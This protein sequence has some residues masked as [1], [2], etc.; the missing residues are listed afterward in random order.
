MRQDIK[1]YVFYEIY[2]NSF[3]DNNNDGYGDLKGIISKLDYVK[4][5]GVDGIWLNP[6]YDSA[7]NDG[8][9]DVKDYFHTSPRFGTDEDFKE[10]ID[11][12]HKRNIKL[13]IDLVP[14]H[15]SEHNP[16]FLKSAEPTRNEFSDRYIWTSDPWDTP[17][18]YRLMTGR[19]DR[20]GSYLVNYFATQPALNYGFANITHPSWQMHYNDER[21]IKTRDFMVSVMEHYLALGVDGFRVDM[22][23]SLVKNDDSKDATV[24][25]WQYMFSKVKAKYPNSIF[26]SEWW[27]PYQAL[28]AGFDCDFVLDRSNAFYNDLVRKEVS[29]CGAQKSFLKIDSDLNIFDNLRVIE[30]VIN[31][32]KD[33]GYLSFF[34]CNHDISR[35][36]FKLDEKELRMF[37]TIIFTLPGV[38]FLYYGDEIMMKY[39]HDIPSKECGFQRTG[40]RTPMSWVDGYNQG[41]SSAKTEDLFLP[42]DET[43]S[44]ERC[45]ANKD[46][47]Y[48]HVKNLIK[49]RHEDESLQ[50]NEFKAIYGDS[51]VLMYERND[52]VVIINPSNVTKKFD[53]NG[54]IVFV[55]GNAYFKDN[56]L[57]VDSQTSVVIKR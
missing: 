4:G 42:I 18:G 9:Y 22:A 29:S 48:Y 32:N 54:K 44:V 14:G 57:Y 33:K 3:K 46:S 12:C 56:A 1:N 38:P 25:V 24:E 28:R 19:F 11:Q 36:S 21:V 10:L 53:L 43:T 15:T 47:I 2:P 37:Y 50:G 5:L 55:D 49:L 8:G 31:D 27:D 41:F 35:P 30:K 39:H 23:D 40:S 7:F 17:N 52:D 16:M 45:M 6:H 20:P 13:L 34:T 51:R 26:V